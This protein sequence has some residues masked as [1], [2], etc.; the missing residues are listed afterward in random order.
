MNPEAIV[1]TE[2]TAEHGAVEL[3]YIETWD[4]LYAPVGLRVARGRRTLPPC[5]AR[6]WQ[7][8]RRYGLDP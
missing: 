4:G 5:I 8:R 3:M 2:T 6:L 7:W 1:V